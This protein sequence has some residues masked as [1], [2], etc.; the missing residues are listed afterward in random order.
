MIHFCINDAT[1]MQQLCRGVGSRVRL[2]CR[3]HLAKWSY[4]SSSKCCIHRGRQVSIVLG[5][6]SSPPSV[7]VSADRGA[8]GV[9]AVAA[10]AVTK[11]STYV[12]ASAGVC[13][14]DGV[15]LCLS[16]EVTQCV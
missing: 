3:Q 6:F 14:L 7:T 11:W 16:V 13:A 5:L 12:G 2:D 1:T 9:A 4:G 8:A 15:C 10:P